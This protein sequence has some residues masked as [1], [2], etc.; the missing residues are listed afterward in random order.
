MNY[1]F[2]ACTTYGIL[3]RLGARVLVEF[4][5][6]FF[7]NVRHKLGLLSSRWLTLGWGSDAF[8]FLSTNQFEL[9]ASFRSR[10]RFQSDSAFRTCQFSILAEKLRK[11]LYSRKLDILRCII[12]LPPPR[13]ALVGGTF[14]REGGGGG[15]VLHSILIE[16]GYA[17]RCDG[18][19]RKLKNPSKLTSDW[20]HSENHHFRLLH[21]QHTAMKHIAI[22]CYS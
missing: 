11:N 18:R 13:C 9:P 14:P 6:C 1:A 12:C 3:I 10:I 20:N 16:E 7:T 17:M 22:D 15:D 21:S 19:R 2:Q 4:L 5:S 8:F